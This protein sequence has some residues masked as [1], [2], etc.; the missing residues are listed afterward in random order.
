MYNTAV[1]ILVLLIIQM[2][3]T[4]TATSASEVTTYRKLLKA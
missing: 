1:C 3:Q 4:L 2:N